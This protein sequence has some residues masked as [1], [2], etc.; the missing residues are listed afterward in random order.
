M[1]GLNPLERVAAIWRYQDSE[2]EAQFWDVLG[3]FERTI[4]EAAS[5]GPSG[6]DA[7]CFKSCLEFY[8]PWKSGPSLTPNDV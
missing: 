7:E 2:T 3:A 8:V 4:D 5:R 1:A 6:L